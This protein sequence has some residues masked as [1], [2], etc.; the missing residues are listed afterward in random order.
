MAQKI[1]TFEILEGD[2]FIEVRSLGE[3]TYKG[4]TMTVELHAFMDEEDGVF[5]FDYAG[6]DLAL[7]RNEDTTNEAWGEILDETYM[8]GG[9]L[10]ALQSFMEETVEGES[11]VTWG[12]SGAQNS[13]NLMFG[14]NYW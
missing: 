5:E 13:E 6:A 14:R 12:E 8:E 3:L 9:I 11:N 1:E 2:D 7:C 4:V 10:A